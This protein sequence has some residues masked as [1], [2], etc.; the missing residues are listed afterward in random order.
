MKDSTEL[1]GSNK[2]NFSFVFPNQSAKPNNKK[3]TIAIIPIAI[4]E[5]A[6]SYQGYQGSDIIMGSNIKRTKMNEQKAARV[7]NLL[8][9]IKYLP[10]LFFF[11]I[12]N[13]CISF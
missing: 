7:R 8:F 10:K 12:T 1:A 5:S 4:Y 2:V 3:S 13:R 9:A 6:F 11:I